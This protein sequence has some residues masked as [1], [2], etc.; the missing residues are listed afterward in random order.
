MSCD[1]I[2]IVYE[3]N[4][5]T[6]VVKGTLIDETDFLIKIKCIPRGNILEIGKRAIVKIDRNVEGWFK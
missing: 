5:Q 4:G 2:K 6:K 3:D 1:T